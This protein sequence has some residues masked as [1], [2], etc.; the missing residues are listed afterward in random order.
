MTTATN[1]TIDTTA[2][3]AKT[4]P[5]LLPYQQRI[6]QT[7][8]TARLCVIEK[9]RRIGATWGL[10]AQAVLVAAA[11]N[12]CNVY[13]MS[14]SVTVARD[15]FIPAAR[16][17]AELMNIAAAVAEQSLV[18]AQGRAFKVGGI[19]F[20]SGYSLWVLPSRA[21]SLRG[22]EGWLILDEAAFHS[23]L[24]AILQAATSFTIWG[25][26]R[27]TILSTHN[28]A[29]NPFNYLARD[30]ENGVRDGAHLRISF[31]D[32][33]SQGLYKKICAVQSTVWTIKAQEKW[34]AKIRSDHGAYAAQ[35][36]DCL[37]SNLAG[38]WLSWDLIPRL[39]SGYGG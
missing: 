22:R 20:E 23:D 33:V 8:R 12:G 5:I 31:A 34:V 37:P 13:Y 9:G 19:R 27:V 39:R 11:Q 16:R 14:T 17:W 28:G 21:V 25:K 35:E 4:K 24:D 38:A 3:T 10:A 1:D 6:N 30:V 15:E 18:D 7:A 29:A 26:G 2:K 36:L 32:A